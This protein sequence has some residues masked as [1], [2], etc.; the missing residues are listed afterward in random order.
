MRDV[1]PGNAGGGRRRRTS[2][3]WRS[4]AEQMT[5]KKD[6]KLNYR[7]NFGEMKRRGNKIREDVQR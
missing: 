5:E 4:E 2:E 6:K 1:E 7:G 3:V